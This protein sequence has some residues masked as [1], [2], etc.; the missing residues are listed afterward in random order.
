L[1]RGFARL[2]PCALH[3]VLHI[4]FENEFIDI[5]QGINDIRE[6]CYYMLSKMGEDPSAQQFMLKLMS[7]DGTL[8]F[9]PR[10][11]HN[12]MIKS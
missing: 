12:D 8:P 9:V 6:A 3:N 1:A 10:D 11:A 7:N 2:S 5:R 4:T